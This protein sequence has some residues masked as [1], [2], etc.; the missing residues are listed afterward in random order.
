MKNEALRGYFAC[1]ACGWDDQISPPMDTLGYPSYDICSCCGIQYGYH[2]IMGITYRAWRDKWVRNGMR[3]NSY[4]DPP[5]DWDPV[6]QL[7]KL[8]DQQRYESRQ[9]QTTG[10]ENLYVF[11][12]D[13]VCLGD[14]AFMAHARG[15]FSQVFHEKESD[16]LHKVYLNVYFGV[17]MA[18]FGRSHESRGLS[19]YDQDFWQWSDIEDSEDTEHPAIKQILYND[20]GSSLLLSYHLY[21]WHS[22]KGFL[23]A[24]LETYGGWIVSERDSAFIY[25]L[26]NFSTLNSI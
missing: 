26:S 6:R 21:G 10:M 16:P 4:S 20:P 5:P 2:D 7:K 19:I 12:A 22:L 14:I 23:K 17:P 13:F 25:D 18:T 1:P 15:Y 8:Q 9:T 3:W 11:T 24:L